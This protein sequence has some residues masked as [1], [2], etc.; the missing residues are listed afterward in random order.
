MQG[1][2]RKDATIEP[3]TVRAVTRLTP[4]EYR[5]LAY[6]AQAAGVTISDT[7]RALVTRKNDHG[8][9]CKCDTCKG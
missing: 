8:L 7:I 1:R 4:E 9:G 5:S 2:R 3:R 6:T